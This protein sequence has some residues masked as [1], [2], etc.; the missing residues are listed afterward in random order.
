[1]SPQRS[2][3]AEKAAGEKETSLGLRFA[4]ERYRE[5]IPRERKKKE[6]RLGQTSLRKRYRDMILW[7]RRGRCH[8]F[9]AH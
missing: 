2:S 8:P 1:M 3:R 7:S 4:G 9:A 5:R 6:A